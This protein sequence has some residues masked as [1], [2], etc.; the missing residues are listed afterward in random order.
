MSLWFVVYVSVCFRNL[1]GVW[2][3][4]GG[5]GTLSFAVK[6]GSPHTTTD[7]VDARVMVPSVSVECAWSKGQDSVRDEE[8]AR[9]AQASSPPDKGTGSP[10]AEGVTRLEGALREAHHSSPL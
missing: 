10:P 9:A 3:I 6:D 4:R 5:P 1:G 8:N 7:S 2:Q